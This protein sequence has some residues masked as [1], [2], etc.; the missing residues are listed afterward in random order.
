M[1]DHFCKLALKC[2]TLCG[3]LRSLAQMTS[4]F[5]QNSHSK[6]LTGYSLKRAHG[7][8]S[9]QINLV[10]SPWRSNTTRKTS[11]LI[12]KFKQCLLL[13]IT[14]K[15]LQISSALLITNYDSFF[16]T[17]YDKVVT[18]CD[19][20]Y[21]LRQN[22]RDLALAKIHFIYAFIIDYNNI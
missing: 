4:F 2:E 10:L 8:G 14:T 3:S 19:R 22:I 1:T 9:F 20:Y 11:L 12:G 17:N 7:I 6:K 15:L 13:Q 21:K 18:N 16:I 5:M